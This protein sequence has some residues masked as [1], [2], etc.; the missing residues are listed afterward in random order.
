MRRA[1]LI[2]L[3]AATSFAA[4]TGP[5]E[6]ASR[7]KDIVNIENVRENQLIGYGLVVGLNGTGDNPRNSPFTTQALASMLERLGV[8]VKPGDMKPANV[9][10]VSVI[11]NLPPYAR[12]GS[13]IDVQIAAMGD[14]TSLQGG[15]LLVTPLLGLDGEAYAAAQGT[16]QVSGFAA[17]G[18]AA[19]VSRG[20]TTSAR[21]PGGAIVEREVAFGFA[22]QNNV[23][24]ALKNPDFTTAQ[25]IAQTINAAL[26]AHAATV[27]DPATVQLSVPASYRDGMIALITRIERLPVDVDETARIVIDEASGTVVMG[28]DVRIS[29]VAIAQGNLT[30]SVAEAPQASQPNPLSKG[31]ET[32]VLPRSA[33]NI[34]D[35][36]GKSMAVI[37]GSASLKDLVGGLNA[38]GVAP[39]DLITILQS[40][41]AAGALQ[42]EIEV[43]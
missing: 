40:L 26:S 30:I 37:D 41:R 23:K 15:T 18:A 36:S 4:L 12:K 25:H 24:L 29:K 34:D 3:T 39:R 43:F 19:S 22:D 16:V 20:S 42:A 14:A 32:V 1:R 7:I 21:V 17:K 10:A 38:L 6:A 11:A 9:A 13:R 35:G 27:L 2:L 33:I 31:G 8:S 28:A 5:A